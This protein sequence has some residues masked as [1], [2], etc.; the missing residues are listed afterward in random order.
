MCVTPRTV[1]VM[2]GGGWRAYEVACRYCWQCQNRRVWDWVGRAIAENET[3]TRSF[4]VTLT[5]GHTDRY[6]ESLAPKAHSL[7]YK[8]VQRWLYRIRK[9]HRVRYVVT[10]EYGSRKGRA[11]WHALLFFQGSVP[12]VKLDYRYWGNREFNVDPFWKDG[13]TM[14]RSFDPL[15]AKYVCKYMLKGSADQTAA[16]I[17]KKPPLGHYYFAQRAERYVEQGLSPQDLVYKFPEVKWGKKNPAPRE[18]VLQGVSAD[19]FLSRFVERW[20]EVH[21]SD[22]W[23]YSEVVEEFLD[24]EARPARE[25]LTLELE[26]DQRPA[27]VPPVAKPWQVPDGHVLYVDEKR[28]LWCCF[29]PS[30][31]NRRPLYWSFDSEGQRAWRDVIVTETQAEAL[32]ADYAKRTSSAAYREASQT[33]ADRRGSRRS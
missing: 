8:D 23:P 3:A 4:F 18:Y 31:P 14:W 15:H 11:H 6:G 32:R 9:K 29:D 1:H 17:S 24:R 20:R 12:D 21:G 28:N 19:N 33:V 30:A 25:V 5:Y 27:W 22:S 16:M 10:G 7:E 13:H 26:R 2:T